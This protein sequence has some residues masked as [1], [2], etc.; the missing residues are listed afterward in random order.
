MSNRLMS[1]VAAWVLA[2]GMAVP[3]YAQAVSS[4]I[5][6]EVLAGDSGDAVGGAQVEITDTR[7][8]A[9]Q[10]L[11]TG[12]DGFF[13]ASGLEVGGPY[14]VRV[15]APGYKPF[16]GRNISITLG[17]PFRLLVGLEREVAA[18]E[19]VVVRA[20]RNPKIDARGV[21]ASYNQNNVRDLPSISRDFKDVISQNP[22]AYQDAGTVI[23][24]A[25][26]N[27]I[28][29][30]GQNPRCNSFLVDGLPVNDSFGL[31]FNGYPTARSP[32]PI[33]WSRQVQV[34][35]SPYNTEYNDFCGGVVNIVT[36]SGENDWR[37]SAYY[38]FKDQDMIGRTIG[39]VKRTKPEFYEENFGA[40]ISGAIIPD[41]LFF[42][43]G[44]DRTLRVTPVSIGPGE[45]APAGT[46]STQVPGITQAEVDQVINI[47]KAVYGYDP[48]A[49]DN[50]F[51]EDNRRWVGKLNWQINEDHRVQVSYGESEGGTLNTRASSSTGLP[52][53]GLRSNWY[54]DAERLTNQSLQLFSKWSDDFSTEFRIG[55]VHVLGD[56][57]PLNGAEFAEVYVRTNGQDNVA[58]NADDGYI[59]I[60]PDQFRHFNILEY[61]YDVV[62]L[63]GT[64]SIDS[65][66]IKGGIERKM[67]DIFNGF[68]QG[69][70]GIY[71][72]N[73]IADF[74]AGIVA[75]AL[76][77]RLAAGRGREPIRYANSPTNSEIRASASWGYTIDSLY[78]QDDWDVTSD[79]SVMFGLR[80]DRFSSDG[81]ITPNAGF[82]A[83]YGFDNT[84][85][86][87]GLD[88]ILPR[89][90]FSYDIPGETESDPSFVIRGGLGQYSGGSPNVWVSN[91]YSNTGIDYVQVQGTP[92]QAVTG[93]NLPA[94][95]F[96]GQAPVNFNLFNVPAA[97]QTLLTFQSGNGP[98]NAL[99]PKFELPSTWRYSAAVDT[100]W[101]D[102]SV[103]AEVL[104]MD[105]QDQLMWRDLRSVDT[106]V[107]TLA[108]NRI[109]YGPKA[110]RPNDGGRDILL[111]NVDEGSAFFL[112]GQ[113]E[114]AWDI[115]EAGQVKFRL[116]Y[117]YSDVQ[118]IGGGTASTADSNFQQRAFVDLNEPLLA[119]SDYEREH[120]FTMG[121][122][123]SYD[124][125]GGYETRLNLFGQH[126]SG[127]P[128]SYVYN[129]NPYGGNGQTFRSLVYVP[130][131]D[132][133]GN[134]TAT[135][136]PNVFYAAG[137]NV[138]AWDAFLKNSGLIQYAGQIAPRNEFFSDW[139]TRVDLSLE[140][141]VKLW[142]DH[143]TIFEFD[144]FNLGNLINN[145][146]G[147]FTSP[148]FFPTQGIV[149]NTVGAGCA[150]IAANQYC[151]SN[152]NAASVPG[153]IVNT[154]YPSSVWQ[155][156]VGVRYEF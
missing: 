129:N 98:V 81:F 110:G 10:T 125:F 82:T 117:T 12:P 52:I 67:L 77:T 109:I 150:G 40:T 62:K 75:S 115:D 147:H 142:G 46:F 137:Y 121:A 132:A 101:E 148:N 44:Y 103:T 35:V 27:P 149:N 19:R 74:Q 144:I 57:A 42:F 5:R 90:S 88:I 146:W 37:G 65:H 85:S 128:Y 114:K 102:W 140:Q 130:K 83:A 122:N 155:I 138:A 8:N 86:L 16:E 13:N 143:K 133:A 73:S 3:A 72:F 123:V 6:G 106:G 28:S 105:L 15:T 100:R 20:Q 50:A 108:D 1:G 49:L 69:S 26:Q 94:A 127:Q 32:L 63:T 38:Y 99:D 45:G 97:L 111:Y 126:M 7:T 53:L 139:A 24:G 51:R 120:R 18:T 22:L 64:Y 93:G 84:K 135:S 118:D 154:G 152:F 56:Q 23:G 131:T 41:K 47:S 91:S 80:Y 33:D 92:G 58:N 107:R 11:T 29:I 87:D 71:R 79:L 36:R 30:A 60:G 136:D 116:G 59:V 14:S 61:T 39:T 34:A 55:R 70:D 113:V 156:Q 76:D 104:Y 78:A 43:A 21:G 134:V 112:I 141:E 68:V 9:R 95:N 25:Q 119:R 151:Y 4:S 145:E 153:S 54:L 31:N 124:F 66:V 17:E 89:A 48:L 96:I 2:L